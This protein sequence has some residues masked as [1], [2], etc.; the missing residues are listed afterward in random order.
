MGIGED[1]EEKGSGWR[2]APDIKKGSE[3]AGSVRKVEQRRKVPKIP[4]ELTPEVNHYTE[5]LFRPWGN[6]GRAWRRI[7]GSKG[8]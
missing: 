8:E 5:W 2:V 7:V 3:E 4:D 1:P 6:V